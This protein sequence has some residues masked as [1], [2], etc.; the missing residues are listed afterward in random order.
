M[1]SSCPSEP[2]G[3]DRAADCAELQALLGAG[4]HDGAPLRTPTLAGALDIVSACR[5]LAAQGAC[6]ALVDDGDRIGV[7]G[8]AE[9]R[10]ALLQAVPPGRRP[11][12]EAARFDGPGAVDG[13]DTVQAAPAL[14]DGR[15]APAL[16]VRN[17]E[18]IDGP[19]GASAAAALLARHS[20][21][22]VLAVDAAGSVDELRPVALRIES[23]LALLRDGGLAVERIARIAGRLN[24]RLHARLWSLLAPP[25]LAA[26]SCLLVMGSEGRGEQI[27]RTDQ[28]NALLLR[29][30]CDDA[31]LQA[32]EA[33]ARRF[34]DALAE[35]GW[36]LC[37]G[38]VMAVNPLWRQPLASFRESLADWVHGHDAE[39][40]LRLAIFV[41]AQ[42][43]A[44]DAALLQRAREQLD[45][46]V[47]DNDAFF[48]RFAVAA[49]R[50]AE[51]GGWW[52][53]LTGH[54]DDQ[55]VDLKKA[56]IFPIVHGMRSLALQY[57]I[58]ATATAERA[59]LLAEAGRLDRGLAGDALDAL[60]L[61]MALRLDRQLRRRREGFD[62]D[63]LLLPA[64]LSTLER[65]QLHG[66]IAIVRRF[67]Q[68]LRLHFRLDS[69]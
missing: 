9:M 56:G 43:V 38:G 30:G 57:G 26:E 23:T 5:E 32:A 22:E 11:L 15:P 8:A 44:G 27:A 59:R 62:A 35:L 12:R 67:R 48:A 17:G 69:L 36:P 25:R 16:P 55:P 52:A 58:R 2:A 40:V 33:A 7:F 6:E 31:C 18:S 42:A 24:R 53:R 64:S 63:N 29:D 66:A 50:F 51:P 13:A 60:H 19:F 54:A 61:L 34:N 21:A 65:D 14:R 39:G 3:D 37:T 4:L 1:P 49:D 10:D 68:F 45:R 41:D 28:D 20:K 47:V 46:F